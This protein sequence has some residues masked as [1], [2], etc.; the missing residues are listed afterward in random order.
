MS[1]PGRLSSWSVRDK[2][3]TL[4]RQLI[5]GDRM[6]RQGTFTVKFSVNFE[7][8]L[9]EHEAE[10]QTLKALKEHLKTQSLEVISI[11]LTSNVRGK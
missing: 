5:G 7:P 11:H 9:N 4:M 2:L 1:K 8:A 10:Y 6:Y 3:L